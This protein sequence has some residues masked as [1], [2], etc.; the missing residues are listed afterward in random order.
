MTDTFGDRPVWHDDAKCRPM[1][2][3]DFFPID[4]EVPTARA[5]SACATCPVFARCEEWSIDEP[6]GFFAGRT[7]L[8]RQRERTRRRL[9]EDRKA[10]SKGKRRTY[11]HASVDLIAEDLGK[12]LAASVGPLEVEVAEL[13]TDFGVRAKLVWLACG[14]LETAGLADV[15][16]VAGGN[17]ILTKKAQT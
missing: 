5:R 10:A 11:G 13:A 17:R 2:V 7:P 4:D 3:D 1:A 14:A 6:D 12:Q 16:P 8:E 15:E 9:A